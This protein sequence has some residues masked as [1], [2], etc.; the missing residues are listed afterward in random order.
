MLS[1]G[2][3]QLIYGQSVFKPLLFVVSAPSG[4]GKTSLCREIAKRT[5]R[6]HYSVSYTTRSPRPGEV[7]GLDYNFVSR[8][9][10]L[11]MK[12]ENLFIESA[13]VYGNLYGTSRKIILDS[14]A[15]GQDV[16]VDIDIQGAE[17]IRKDNFESISIYILPPSRQILEER[18]SRRGQDSPE[19]LRKRLEK[20]RQEV[21]AFEH[22]DYLVFNVDFAQAVEDLH[23]IIL[24]EHHRKNR[25]A[26]FVRS[27]FLPEFEK[28]IP[29][30]IQT[31]D[32]RL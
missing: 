15:Q 30:L 19:T 26:D 24:S 18:L 8:E 4:A 21:H 17:I 16:L 13:E 27:H 14:F 31:S 11:Q 1:D 12:N 25:M 20:V 22:Y 6:I 7:N 28:E 5:N 32:N 10:F 23:S 2:L 3:G 9:Q 29:Q